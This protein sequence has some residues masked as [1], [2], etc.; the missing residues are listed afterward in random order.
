LNYFTFPFFGADIGVGQRSALLSIL[1]AL[2]IAP[3]FHTLKKRTKNSIPIPISFLL[4]VDNGLLIF[5]KKNLKN[6]M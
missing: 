2:Y 5:Q 4:F 6:Q 1:L 3:I